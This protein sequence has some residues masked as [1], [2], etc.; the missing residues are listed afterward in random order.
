MA[1]IVASELNLTFSYS[2]RFA[3]SSKDRLFPVGYR[4]PNAL[5][6]AVKGTRI[7][8]VNDVMNAG[9]AVRRTFED[10]EACGA[11]IVAIASLLTL[12]DAAQQFADSRHVM[13]ESLLHLPNNLWTPSACPLCATHVPLQDAGAFRNTSA[14]NS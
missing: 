8:I 6:R 3:K 9:S 12:G 10:L 11:E 13:L 5:R 7:A 14:A 4:V 1:L 2:E